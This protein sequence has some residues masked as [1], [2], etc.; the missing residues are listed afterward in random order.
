MK[1][2]KNLLIASALGLMA[3]GSHAAS[4]V[5][6]TEQT[7]S[8]DVVFANPQTLKAD[9]VATEGLS[10]GHYE[11]NDAIA[12]LTVTSSDGKTP[13]AVTGDYNA[14]SYN[15]GSGKWQAIGKNGNKI[16]VTFGG[17]KARASGSF[18]ADGFTWWEYNAG[19]LITVNLDGKQDV[20][21]DTYPITL[22]VAEYSE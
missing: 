22:H 18:Q 14:E 7:K 17:V 13:F 11:N 10:A 4:I 15:S 8:V 6:G 5:S 3:A 9:F 1:N 21:A 2:M 20:A 12:K 19:D 16:K